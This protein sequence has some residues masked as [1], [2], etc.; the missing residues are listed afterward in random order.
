ML[1]RLLWRSRFAPAYRKRWSERFGFFAAPERPGAIWL[2]AVSLGETRA[3]LPL[4]RA[5]IERYPER[6]IAVTTTTPTGSAQVIESFGSSVFHT[7]LPY[8]LPDALARFLSKVR[9]C[10]AIIME[11]EIWPNLYHACASTDVPIVIA[12]ARLSARSTKGYARLGG[13]TRQTL[14]H[15]KLIAAQS[16]ADAQRF[17]ALG[18]EG[19]KL[20]VT[21]NIKYDMKLPAGIEAES[22]QFKA[23]LGEHRPVLIAASTHDGEEEQVL[24]AFEVISQKLPGV[25]LLLVP[26]HPE[27]FDTVAA[28]CEQRG[29][30]VARRS[31]PATSLQDENVFLGDSMGELLLFYAASNVA[32]V[33]GSLVPTGGHNLL[34]PAALG[35]SVLTGPHTFNFQATQDFIRAGAAIVVESPQQLAEQ[36]LL[37][38]QNED[39]RNEMGARAKNIVEENR[40]ALERLMVTLESIIPY[41]SS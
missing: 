8:D 17:E 29:F 36:A 20:M 15:V 9:P 34:E 40:G 1:L 21:G 39:Q 14:S 22:K 35:K 26:R 18:V 10:I 23:L 12:N 3:A 30:R 28:L 31:E 32:F 16:E 11:T 24:A 4:L 2:H 13:L 27:R 37:L 5:L 38:L 7:Y 33:G 25:L 41:K 19:G 6:P